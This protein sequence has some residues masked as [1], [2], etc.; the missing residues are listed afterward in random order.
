MT[1]P[2]S[3]LASL[4]AADREDF[5]ATL[6]SSGTEARLRSVQLEVFLGVAELLP[7]VVFGYRLGRA[8]GSITADVWYFESYD[9]LTKAHARLTA[10]TPGEAI[11]SNGSFLVRFT[12]LRPEAREALASCVQAIAGEE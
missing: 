4:S 8:G 1:I 3:A 2:A 10:A 11:T 12:A 5:L 7:G 9:A 6:K